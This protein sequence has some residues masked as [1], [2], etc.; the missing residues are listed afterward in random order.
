MILIQLF[1]LSLVN[2]QAP[3]CSPQGLNHIPTQQTAQ[4]SQSQV[5][6]R[7]ML[8]NSTTGAIGNQSAQNFLL[9]DNLQPKVKTENAVALISAPPTVPGALPNNPTVVK[10]WHQSV[11]QDLRHHLVQKM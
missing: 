9:T 7:P 1:F 10:D 8:Q 11:T 6:N 2:D 3:Q 4:N 5:P